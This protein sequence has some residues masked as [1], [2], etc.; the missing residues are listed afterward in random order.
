MAKT[1]PRHEATSHDTKVPEAIVDR[2]RTV[3]SSHRRSLLLELSKTFGALTLASAIVTLSPV[4][5]A[6]S[7]EGMVSAER[8]SQLLRDVP[9]FTIVDQ[10]GVPF[11]VVGEDAKVTGYFFTEF[12][13]AERILNLA[14]TSA[15]KLIAEAKAEQKASGKHPLDP[16]ELINPWKE[17]RISTI[18]LDTAVALATRSISSTS[19]NF[20]QVAASSD[21]IEDALTITG[22]D[23]LAEN[24]VPLFYYEDFV[25]KDADGN[26]QNP[27]YF[28]QAELEQA[29]QKANPGSKSRP[30]IL[31]TELF[32]T[33]TEMVRPGGTDED[34]KKIVFVA[35]SESKSRAKECQ[36]KGGEEAPFL[37]GQRNVVL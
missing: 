9:T 21:D 35:P 7:D 6:S 19:K 18:P 12:G 15:D 14:R 36:R 23:E 24:R 2:P 34:L 32:A 26:E 17:A 16:E 27:L 11:M 37:L 25:V 5:A 3:D 1:L 10:K 20:F 33:M 28:R 13:E 4:E 22:K 30:P 31:V 8:L 29:Y